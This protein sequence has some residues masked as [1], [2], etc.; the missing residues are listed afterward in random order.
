MKKQIL[1]TFGLVGLLTF[2]SCTKED[3]DTPQN[4]DNDGILVSNLY[5]PQDTDYTQNPPAAS[6]P[7]VKFDFSTGTTT[8]SDTDWDIA[9]RGTTIL[10]NGG[11]SSGIL[12]AP[13]RI[14][15]AGAYITDG[16][17]EEIT[18]IN[19]GAF[20][21]DGPDGLAIPTGSGNGWYT[22]DPTQLT[23]L[24]IPGKVIVL[25]TADNKYAKIE[26]LSYYKDAPQVIND[27]IALN[28][29]RYYTFNYVYQDDAGAGGF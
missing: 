29:L 3:S 13:Q 2:F 15:N 16:I 28:D 23:I 18:N 25:R 10:I 7:F 19:L 22:Y 6:G 26:I 4:T 14:G 11:S 24:P 17:F 9:F 27:Q 20:A 21:Q 12:D 8:T 1:L 5:A